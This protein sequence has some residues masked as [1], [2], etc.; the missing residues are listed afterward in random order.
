[1][2]TEPGV[3]LGVEGPGRVMRSELRGGARLWRCG[4]AETASPVSRVRR[5]FRGPGVRAVGPE[6]F[7]RR[8]RRSL[9]VVPRDELRSVAGLPCRPPPWRNA[10]RAHGNCLAVGATA[11]NGAL[12]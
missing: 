1:M 10:T 9:A 6:V 4:N 11:G 12:R 2:S 8:A 5:R 3:S 7:R